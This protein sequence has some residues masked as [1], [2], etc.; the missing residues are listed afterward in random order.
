MVEL[1][2]HVRRAV[3]QMDGAGPEDRPTYFEIVTAVALLRFARAEVDL[4][5]LEVGLGG[6]LDSTN[7]CNP[8]V[9]A[10]TS[11][12]FDHMEQLGDSVEAIA[13]EK[14]GIIKSGVPVVNGETDPAA[15]RVIRE[16]AQSAAAPVFQ[17]GIDF[18][19]TRHEAELNENDWPIESFDYHRSG[20]ETRERLSLRC[21]APIR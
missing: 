7:V 4:A 3:T 14:A 11:I 17:R 5:V 6:R 8:L 15:V 16:M 21:P 13:R 12:S 1:V 19:F 2:E 10:I 18:D 9:T 20:S